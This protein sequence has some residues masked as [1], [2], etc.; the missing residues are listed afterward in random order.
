MAKSQKYE[1]FHKVQKFQKF[2]QVLKKNL[3]KSRIS[4][5]AN[6]SIST[7]KLVQI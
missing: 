7:A 2:H 4:K 1:K 3:F 6:F 5:I